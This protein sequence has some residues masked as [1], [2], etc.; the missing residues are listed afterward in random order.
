M[1]PPAISKFWIIGSD[2]VLEA[3]QVI[4]WLLIPVECLASKETSFSSFVHGEEGEYLLSAILSP[5]PCFMSGADITSDI[6]SDIS[7][8]AL[9]SVGYAGIVRQHPNDPVVRVLHRLCA[10]NFLP[11]IRD[12]PPL[13]A[14]ARHVHWCATPAKSRLFF[15]IIAGE[16]SNLGCAGIVLR[17]TRCAMPHTDP[18]CAATRPRGNAVHLKQGTAH[19]S[20]TL[21]FGPPCPAL[22]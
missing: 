21:P 15:S 9:H 17:S 22:T 14:S 19:S 20:A 16:Y 10:R 8:R 4:K 12:Q 13:S 6:S 3:S 7:S 5:L 11:C 1:F 2:R 18:C